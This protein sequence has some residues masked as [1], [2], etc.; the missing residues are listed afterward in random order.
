MMKM[1]KVKVK[2]MMIIIIIIIITMVIIILIPPSSS[3]TQKSKAVRGETVPVLT[4][5]GATYC[6]LVR[7][8]ATVTMITDTA[9]GGNGFTVSGK[10]NAK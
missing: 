7:V 5:R 10:S 3:L 2:V 6:M 8:C 9:A 4:N 1:K